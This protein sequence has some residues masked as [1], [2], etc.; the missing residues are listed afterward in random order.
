MRSVST[1]TELR[2]HVLG[3]DTRVHFYFMCAAAP[4]SA[5]SEHVRHQQDCFRFLA[6]LF[7]LP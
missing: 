7:F 5:I 4:A 3:S 2:E 1:G 6:R